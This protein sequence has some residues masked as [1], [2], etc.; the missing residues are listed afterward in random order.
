MTDDLAS[1]KPAGPVFRLGR[2]KD[3]WEWPDWSYAKPDGTFGNRWD[4]P[5]GL[6]RVLYACS[7]R[8]GTFIETLARFRPDPHV[9]AGL[10]AISGDAGNALRPGEVPKSWLSNRRIGEATFDGDCVAVGHSSSLAWLAIQMADRLA[11][12]SIDE[13]D[14]AAIRL[15][16]P[17]A[18]TQEISRRVFEITAGGRRRYAGI[19]YQSR[20][21]DEFENWAIFEPAVLE[22]KLAENL[23]ETDA[24]LQEA[25]ARLGLTLID[26]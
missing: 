23:A 16:L 13:L 22:P 7:Q 5:Q 8:L 4:D 20:L 6:Y 3:P 24:D 10:S 25:L 12:Y 21:G 19:A 17:R 9:V 11:E 14:A 2:G 26:T 18:F 1:V 15:S